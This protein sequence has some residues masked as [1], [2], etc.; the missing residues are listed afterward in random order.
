MFFVNIN[1][2]F[3]SQ[4]APIFFPKMLANEMAAQQHASYVF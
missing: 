1:Q 2:S 4:P 3:T